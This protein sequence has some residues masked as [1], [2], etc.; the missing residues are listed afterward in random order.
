VSPMFLAGEN[1]EATGLSGRPLARDGSP[2]TWC[3]GGGRGRGAEVG[4]QREDGSL[5]AEEGWEGL[6]DG[7]ELMSCL[8]FTLLIQRIQ[9]GHFLMAFVYQ[10]SKAIQ[11][12]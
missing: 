1:G 2:A 12:D 7:G 11:L 8:F 6:G 4:L 10:N 5:T 3:E 9:S